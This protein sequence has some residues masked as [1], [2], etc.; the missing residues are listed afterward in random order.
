VSPASPPAIHPRRD[1]LW[2]LVGA[3][4]IRTKILGIVLALVLLLGLG[5]TFQVR[6]ALTQT[7]EAQLQE[8]SVSVARDL[9]GRAT[10]LIL[11]ND[12]YAL[13]RLLRETLDNNANVRYAFVL[14][15][16]GHVLAHTF[17]DGF[18][19]GLTAANTTAGQDHHRT[20]IL[21]TDAGRVWDTAVPIF[22]GQAGTARVGLTDAGVRRAV[23]AVTGQLLLTT[24]LVSI[25]GVT[26]A[27]LLTWILTRPILNLVQ[28]A[29]A[30]GQGDFNQRVKRWAD[31]EIGELSDAF[32]GMAAA[33]ARAAEER[34]EREQLRAKYVKGVITA[35]EEE[36][37][38][39]ARELHDSTSQSLTSLLLG[40]R[41]L[42]E[43]C[44]QP[45]MRRRSEELRDVAS[46][47][48]DEVHSLA[49]QLRPSVLDDLGLAAALERMIGDSRIRH[50]ARIDLAMRGLGE[51]R[52]PAEVETAVYRIVQ[53]AL[54]NIARHAQAQTASVLI[55]RQ[56]GSV[57]AII[58]DDGRGFEPA[59][60]DAA[61]RRLGLYGMRERAELLGGNLT[62]ESEPGRGTSLFVEI[63]LAPGNR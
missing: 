24:I 51:E 52:L 3:V 40:L 62:I 42:G 35:Q 11:I 13:H 18:P 57:R 29:H 37:K 47:T 6:G 43:V 9:A 44:N 30:V 39:I 49:L 26:A 22:E 7:M 23:D 5:I 33:L 41:S 38:R 27:A 17:G 4:S 50:G 55:E 12:L 54:T 19:P 59:S 36:R 45:E 25:I 2:A 53:E 32:N 14:D 1:R 10:D 61:D 56:N 60:M 63:P 58:E 46:H 8:Q 28:A 21:D 48:L 20:A 34:A 16:G 31:D 15:A